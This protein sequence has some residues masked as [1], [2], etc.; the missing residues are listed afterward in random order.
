MKDER[1]RAQQPNYSYMELARRWPLTLLHGSTGRGRCVCSALASVLMVAALLVG[2]MPVSAS[3]PAIAC[4]IKNENPWAMSTLNRL[5]DALKHYLTS[6]SSK[7]FTIKTSWGTFTLSPSIQAAAAANLKAG[8]PIDI[9]I[10]SWITGDEFFVPVNKGIAAAAAH[11]HTKSTLIGPVNSNQ[12]EEI[13]D[14]G[15]YM[16]RKPAGMAVFLANADSGKAIVDRLVK[17]GVPVIIWNADAANTKRLAYVGQDNVRSGQAV[18]QFMAKHLKAKHITS[19]TIALFATDATASY[20][21]ARTAG[22]KKAVSAALPKV[23]FSTQVSLGTD[24]SAAVGKVDAAVRGKPGI[25]GMYSADEQIMAAAIWEQRY[26]TAGQYV[27][28]GHNLLPKELQLMKQGYLSGVVGQNPYA[29]GYMSVQWIYQFVTTGKVMC[30][31]CDT[32][33]PVVDSAAVAA[34]L[35]ASNCN[36]TGCA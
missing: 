28:A 25:V 3:I 19:G 13:S 2:V 5:P 29:Q 17:S 7:P 22:F 35:L 6:Y 14:I 18:G 33:Y 36:G 30:V 24:I 4:Q 27:I 15:S 23:K 34:K 9:P 12:P 10:F 32:G 20:A 16:A 11:F 31:V 26:A 21:Q 8:K 1:V